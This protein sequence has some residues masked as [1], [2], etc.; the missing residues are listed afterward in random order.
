M[1]GQQQGAA[2]GLGAMSQ[3]FGGLQTGAAQGLGAQGQAY[4]NATQNWT[5]GL[6]AMTA[7]QAG[8]AQQQGA[9]RRQQG[10]G[11]GQLSES[12]KGSA[13]SAYD[14]TANV[15]AQAQRGNIELEQLKAGQTTELNKE[16]G[17]RERFNQETSAKTAEKNMDFYGKLIG[18]GVG[19]GG[20][21]GMLGG[22]LSDERSKQ[23]LTRAYSEIDS[24]RSELASM[25]RANPAKPSSLPGTRGYEPTASDDYDWN[26]GA[27]KSSAAAR[28][29]DGLDR[30]P[31]V[32]PRLDDGLGA[33]VS[34]DLSRTEPV[35]YQYRPEAVARFPSMTAPGQRYGVTAQDLEQAGPVGKSMVREGPGG[36]KQI[37]PGQA[38][39]AMLASMGEQQREIDELKAELERMRGR[40]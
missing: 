9:G 16:L 38:S 35:G 11:F 17:E 15:G 20:G 2:Q 10:L 14:Q 39:G 34:R 1:V 7:Q 12:S 37:D 29:G 8:L 36:L 28:Y 21:G 27:P 32:T 3:S 23:N 4:S 40:R 13:L 22:I 6:G 33:P 25:Y 30:V 26:T 19:G 18:S 31:P 5:Q 24:L